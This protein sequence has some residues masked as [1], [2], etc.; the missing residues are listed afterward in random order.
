M[1]LRQNVPTDVALQ[2]ARPRAPASA[3]ALGQQSLLVAALIE[4]L[5]RDVVQFPLSVFIH[6]WGSAP[7]FDFIKLLLPLL[8]EQDALWLVSTETKTIQSDPPAI[9]RAM[10]LKLDRD[11]DYWT[12]M[13]L[14]GDL[15]FFSAMEE[16]E[17]TYAP[18]FRQ[19]ARALISYGSGPHYESL[20]RVAAQETLPLYSWV[21]GNT[22]SVFNAVAGP[23]LT[24][25]P[26]EREQDEAQRVQVGQML[27]DMAEHLEN[28]YDRR[29]RFRGELAKVME[30]YPGRPN[31]QQ[32]FVELGHQ[33]QWPLWTVESLPFVY[34]PLEPAPDGRQGVLIWSRA[35]DCAPEAL[36]YE[37]TAKLWH[38]EFFKIYM[39]EETARVILTIAEIF[40]DS[41]S[42]FPFPSDRSLAGA[43]NNAMQQIEI[44]L[45]PEFPKAAD[46]VREMR[47]GILKREH[48]LPLRTPDSPAD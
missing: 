16:V 32:D 2:S 38:E 6:G 4:E 11:A 8:H 34:V 7:A 35:L 3:H 1:W 21:K 48:V 23:E 30:T 20:A 42:S 9:E 37:V 10:V 5:R 13:N 46:K 25:A 44:Y 18:A 40:Q 41:V 12:Y 33:Y 39:P 45:T 28:E 22:L 14:N 47:K 29:P 24:A 43:I 26:A 36:Q 15:V 19:R 27:K 31:W 17:L